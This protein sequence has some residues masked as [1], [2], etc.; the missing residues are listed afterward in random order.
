MKTWLWI[1]YVLAVSACAQPPATPV[2][3]VAAGPAITLTSDPVPLNADNPQQTAIGA[4][5]YAGGLHLTSRDTTQLHGLSDLRVAANGQIHAVTDEG[6]LFTARLVLDSKGRLV[7]AADGALTPLTGTDGQV[8]PSKQESDAEGLAMLASG[9][10]LVSLERHHRI[11]LYPAKGGPPREAPL[12][13]AN[14]PDNG[15]MEGLS[16]DPARGA[17]AYLVGGEVSGQTWS[18]TLAKGCTPGR[19]I[20]KTDDFGLVALA[21]LSGDRLAYLLRSWDPLRGS[22][23]SLIIAD[24]L[25]Q[26]VDQLDLQRPLTV[27]NFEGLAAVPGKSGTIRFYLLADDNF[28]PAERTLLL[29]FDW[30]PQALKPTPAP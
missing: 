24:K 28:S 21:P 27:D 11:L 30:T 15:G 10:R 3:P 16:E 14:F 5:A 26:V 17:D 7:G 8:L 1:A 4:F 13:E 6:S 29:A 19:I 25:G 23:V 9:D 20:P 22:R 12:P 18:C 2:G